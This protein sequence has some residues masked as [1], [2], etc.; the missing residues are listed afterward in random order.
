[1]LRLLL[2]EEKSGDESCAVCVSLFASQVGYSLV[3]TDLPGKVWPRETR[4][5]I[6]ESDCD[7]LFQRE[8]IYSEVYRLSPGTYFGSPFCFMTKSLS[9]VGLDG[10]C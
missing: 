6:P 8:T 4:T 7:N 5:Y 9:W 2:C 3:G 10:L 1:M